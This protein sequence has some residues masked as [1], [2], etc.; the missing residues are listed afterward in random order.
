MDHANAAVMLAQMQ[1][2]SQSSAA[3]KAPVP[4]PGPSNPSSAAAVAAAAAAAAQMPMG[5]PP[6]WAFWSSPA[7][8]AAAAAAAAAASAGMW[9]GLPHYPLMAPLMA[10]GNTNS[11]AAAAAAAAAMAAAVAGSSASM[12][13]MPAPA[14]MT[15]SFNAA[16]AAAAAMAAASAAAHNGPAASV[17]NPLHPMMALATSSLAPSSLSASPLLSMSAS[18]HVVPS[19]GVMAR[20]SPSGSNNKRKDMDDSDREGTP[21]GE[22]DERER[23]M[24]KSGGP[25]S[26]TQRRPTREEFEDEAEFCAAYQRWRQVRDRNND[27]VK[28]SREKYKA[29]KKSTE[30][31]SSR[32]RELEEQLESLK[33]R[34]ALFARALTKPGSLSAEE[35]E[36]LQASLVQLQHG[37]GAASGVSA[38]AGPSSPSS[39]ASPANGAAVPS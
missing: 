29:K 10:S 3:H 11:Q 37:D 35:Q 32:E 12:S 7:A 26:G 33:A 14:D 13:M 19:G 20:A 21:V 34:L 39:C 24:R 17:P 30:V 25:H 16:A 38:N 8:Q 15:A 36:S 18:H 22:L 2:A 5:M 6:Q 9:P 31:V 28:R 1:A 23:A 4:I 27:A